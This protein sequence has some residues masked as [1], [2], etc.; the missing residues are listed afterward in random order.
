[1][2]TIFNYILTSSMQ[3][4]FLLT[5]NKINY[6]ILFDKLKNILQ[7]TY[8]INPKMDPITFRTKSSMSAIRL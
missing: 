1:M 6:F 4:L 2:N 3:L 8:K 7:K 5:T